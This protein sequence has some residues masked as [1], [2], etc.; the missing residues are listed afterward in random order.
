MGKMVKE[1]DVLAV[2]A[3]QCSLREYCRCDIRK[4]LRNKDFSEEKVEE[5]IAYLVDEGYISDKRYARAYACDKSMLCGWGR[6]KIF[7]N[8]RKKHISE[9]IL[10]EVWEELEHSPELLDKMRSVISNKW[11]SLSREETRKRVEKTLRFALGR[12]FR[13]EQIMR[14]LEEKKQEEI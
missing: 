7:F 6:E 5:I 9:D 10:K 3:H 4:K 14:V 2:L 12:G 1:Q 13:Y 11:N 8:L